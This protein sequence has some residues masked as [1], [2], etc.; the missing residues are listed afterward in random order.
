MK[1][2]SRLR[3]GLD[4]AVI[5]GALATIPLTVLQEQGSR[6]SALDTLDWVV[7]SIFA[8]EFLVIL[9]LAPRVEIR[10]A[11]TFGKFG[12]VLLSFP[13]LPS[14]LAL[15]RLARLVRLLRLLRLTGVTARGLAALKEIFGR[16]GVICT[17]AITTLLVLV[18]GGCVSILEPQTVKGG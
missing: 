18:G 9:L 8:L 1:S 4:S 17:L 15:V 2:Q 12:V 16:R 14:L 13:L 11:S 7:W 6:F 5:L 3:A 10:K